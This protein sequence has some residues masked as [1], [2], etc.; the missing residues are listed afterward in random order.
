[1]G[2]TPALADVTG[3]IGANTTPENRHVRGFAVGTGV[4]LIGVEFEYAHTPEDAD[5]S[6]P[7]LNTGMGNLLLQTPFMIFG[8]QPYA[9]AGAGFYRET[10]G[11][12]K[13]TGFA[14]ACGLPRAETGKRCAVFTSAPHLCRHQSEVLG[15]G[16]GRSY[17]A[18]SWSTVRLTIFMPWA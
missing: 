10:L 15:A 5:A 8:F 4:L 12:R 13:D 7:E 14:A 18:R 6:A 2:A 16:R 11:T 9:T 3:F 17:L 1:M